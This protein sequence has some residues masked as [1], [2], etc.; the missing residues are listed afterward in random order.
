MTHLARHVWFN[1]SSCLSLPR[2]HVLPGMFSSSSVFLPLR[3]SSAPFGE[4]N[5]SPLS[6]EKVLIVSLQIFSPC[7]PEAMKVGVF[8]L[9]PVLKTI[10]IRTLFLTSPPQ[11]TQPCANGQDQ[12]SRQLGQHLNWGSGRTVVCSCTLHLFFFCPAVFEQHSWF[13]YRI[14]RTAVLVLARR[15]FSLVAGVLDSV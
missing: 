15:V 12:S 7:D 10:S 5:W 1:Y 13:T 4:Q 9:C 2:K 14:H 6:Q 8:H 11:G 3:Y